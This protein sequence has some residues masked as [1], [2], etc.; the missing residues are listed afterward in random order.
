[1]LKKSENQDDLLTFSFFDLKICV[2]PQKDSQKNRHSILIYYMKF[3]SKK[4]R[5]KTLFRFFNT[6]NSWVYA[7]W[8]QYSKKWWKKFKKILYLGFNEIITEIVKKFG[9][10]ISI[11]QSTTI[12]ENQKFQKILDRS[13]FFFFRIH[14]K[15]NKSCHLDK[16]FF[17][18]KKNY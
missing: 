13:N 14:K 11:S 3:L 10:H 7:I 1:M 9:V 17:F 16:L 4:M 12:F 2:I 8:G 6:K 5:K 15:L 18:L